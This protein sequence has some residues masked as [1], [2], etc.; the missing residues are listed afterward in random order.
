VKIGELRRVLRDSGVLGEAGIEPTPAELADALWLAALRRS[1]QP[2]LPAAAPPPVEDIQV[3][4]ED[5]GTTT[6]EPTQLSQA[7]L[8]RPL[9]TTQPVP[10]PAPLKPQPTSQVFATLPVRG[11]PPS[12]VL[13]SAAARPQ[14]LDSL[15][16]ARAMRPLRRLVP[17]ATRQVL[18]EIATADLRAEQ[19]LWMPALV[20]GSEPAF[21][22]A[23][24]VDDSESMALWGEKVRE[25]R[26]LCERLGAFRDVRLWHL[27]ANDDDATG[28]DGA[29]KPVLR[30]LSRRSR[31]RDERELVD[32]SGRRLILVVTDGV[33][34]WWRPSGPLGPVLARW[35]LAS[36]L[37]IVQPFPQRLWE[38]SP[39]RLV[40]EEFRPGWPGNGPTIQ[41]SDPGS[42]AVP[43]LELAPAA[44]R[45]WTGIISGTS[46]I[47][48]LPAVALTDGSAAE[49]EADAN[50]RLEHGED[51]GELDPA[52]IVRNFRASVSP[53]AYQLAGYLSAAPLTLP[54]MRLVQES[55]MPEAGPAELAEVFLSGL[56]RKA[57]NSAPAA[58]AESASYVFAAGVRDVLQSTLTRDEAVSVLDQVGGH[59][60][61]GRGGGRPFPVLLRGEQLGSDIPAAA[62]QFPTTFGRIAGPLL[63]RIGGPYA[64]AIRR[65]ATLDISRAIQG[66]RVT[67][68]L[69]LSRLQLTALPQEICQLTEL[70]SLDLTGNQLTVLPPEIGQLSSLRSFSANDNQLIDLPPE[71]GQLS[72][73][74]S[75]EVAGNQLT[76][77]PPQ[78]ADLLTNGLD[79]WLQDN[80]L[81]DPLAELIDR[82][83]DALA[84]YLHSLRDAV[85]QYEAKVLVVGEGGVG[86][87][88][89]IASLC[90]KQFVPNRAITHGID[91]VNLTTRHPEI[92]VDMTMRI[93]D[94]GG[95]E[96]YRVTH[97]LFFSQNALYILVWNVREGQD[98]DDV[99]GWLRRIHLRAGPVARVL[100]VSTH[101]EER[102]PDLDY[103]HLVQMFPE[104]L[105]GQYEI[106]N[107]TANGID[108][109]RR[110]IAVEIA[111]LPQ[112]GQLVS[113]RWAAARDVVLN[114]ANVE[115]TISYEQFAEVCH[116]YQVDGMEMETLA[117][118]MHDLGQI[119]YYGE[120]E[121][122]R[123]FVVL[124][125]EWVTKAIAYVLEDKKTREAGGILD[126]ARL[127]EIWR[128][129]EER[130]YLARYHQYL[131]R[132]MEK[133][134]LSYR[135]ES[136]EYRSLIAQLVPHR[137]P[138]L[139][140]DFGTPLSARIR[141]LGMVSQLDEPAPGLI[142]WLTVRHH[143]ASTGR[144]WRTGVFL[145]HPIP[146]YDSEALLELTSPTQLAIEVR[147]PSPDLYF[148][149][150][151]DSIETLIMTRWPGLSYQLFIPC[152]SVTS[153]GTR[154]S[155]LL[156][157]D[158][159]LAYREEGDSRYLCVRCRT[160]HD[161]S[162]L[163][164]GFPVPV[165][166]LATDILQ[167]LERIEDRLTRMEDQAADTAA[168]I[169]R[170]Q[171]VV[172]AE[173]T[174][175]PTLFTLSQKHQASNE[176]KR[177]YR[178]HYQLT[179]W[180]A[181]PGYWHP[182][183]A[184]TYDIDPPKEWL[185]RVGPYVQLVFRTLQLVVPLAGSIAVVSLPTEQAES[186]TAQL[187]MMK[188]LVA[189]LPSLPTEELADFTP[190]QMTPAEGEAI[191]ALRALIFEYDPLR[192][193]GGLRRVQSP[194]GDFLWVC[195]NHYG[196][197]DPG[198]PNI[199]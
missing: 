31:A 186:A 199:P 155:N 170:V 21:D 59:L 159:L 146:A 95:Q 87:S 13:V 7:E 88:S 63:A 151:Y 182:W 107:R 47:A 184:A 152:P 43:I 106:D 61:R 160:R 141:S 36:P 179:L 64:D 82:G 58:D 56:L 27:S 66:A 181:H 33:H 130:G 176:L 67:G 57:A 46:G 143:Q 127:P 99:E 75:L 148:H 41:R 71:I 158:D 153:D 111:R 133:F 198:L 16:L 104:M 156:L 136:D 105:A 48:R 29:A 126:H 51:A 102:R 1:A 167:Q 45:R 162:A 10:E 163:L 68:E 6:Q 145:R 42:V 131:L 38:R 178:N 55:M 116:R 69:N 161:I 129:G 26:L 122:L 171:S 125:P 119:T 175:C 190:G 120:D 189:D 80:P 101:C 108:E 172:A 115:P 91:V 60:V 92:D 96:V 22:L 193:F 140:W 74:Q 114:R 81:R 191:R 187:G 89:L 137:R 113:P 169:R 188:T 37:A 53:T 103:P 93:W 110:A 2:T 23:L 15:A 86:K 40:I 196:E 18:D 177:L 154:C 112:M 174:D 50:V 54:V 117:R 25:F 100:L 138:D 62:E 52:R 134:D 14:L 70:Q 142:A 20:Q 139:P 65:E 8:S 123:D 77:L 121:G 135:L 185:S 79:I 83:S 12:G 94:F 17:S 35:A 11:T 180:C 85:P 30:G 73:L 98:Q 9:A 49:D 90:G 32:L 28:I 132:L 128:G 44:M 124:S 144:H 76:F 5:R 195:S 165:Q 173:M 78:I 97:Q 197:Y 194:S 34:P 164:T 150:I 149:V 39:L 24:V 166:P 4:S 157:M 84:S 118:L 3:E 109:L 72:A 147:A 183:D 192:K 168:V 19:G